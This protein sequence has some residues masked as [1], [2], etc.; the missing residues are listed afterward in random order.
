MY[1]FFIKI[2]EIS[3]DQKDTNP[4]KKWGIASSI[5]IVNAMN[6]IPDPSTIALLKGILIGDTSDLDEET[7]KAF[8]DSG[9]AHLM[10]VSGTNITFLL[11]PLVFLF[12]KSGV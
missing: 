6:Q 1:I 4:L 7:K 3:L 5:N 8:S 11:I 12:K 2:E 10:S 9:I